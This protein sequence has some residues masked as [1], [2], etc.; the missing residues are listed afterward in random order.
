[1][2]FMPP[3]R[4]NPAPYETGKPISQNVATYGKKGS[5]I[6]MLACKQITI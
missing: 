5:C 1:M 3:N 6:T 4:G 2:V